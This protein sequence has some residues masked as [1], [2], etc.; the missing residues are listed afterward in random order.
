MANIGLESA[1]VVPGFTKVIKCFFEDWIATF[2][3]VF[4]S[5]YDKSE[6]QKMAEQAVMEIEGAVMLS[7]LFQDKKYFYA[8]SGRI[9][10][11]LN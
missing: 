9:L 7:V 6:A 8:T 10:S 3:Y 5:E 2:T 4:Q 11:Y 1:Q